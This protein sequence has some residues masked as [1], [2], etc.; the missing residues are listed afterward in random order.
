MDGLSAFL[1]QNVER[2]PNEK[3]VVSKRF[4]DKKGKPIEWEIQAITSE[5]NDDL[6]RRSMVTRKLVNG[7]SVREQDSVKYT[8][9]MLTESVVYPD[10]NNAELQ[11]SYGVKTPEAL[12]K[13]MLYPS[14]ETAL[15][16]AVLKL[17]EMDD[18]SKDIEEA[19]N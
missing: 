13:K 2:I 14:E 5:V 19:K 6:Q 12:L 16:K 8:S 17:S 10:L 7:Q 3:V 18:L 15:A 1:A 4:K 11:D 9:L